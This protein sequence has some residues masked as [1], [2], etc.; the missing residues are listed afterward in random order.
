ME[1][2]EKLAKLGYSYHTD[3][4]N[5]RDLVSAL[6]SLNIRLPYKKFSVVAEEIIDTIPPCDGYSITNKIK[7]MLENRVLGTTKREAKKYLIRIL[8]QTKISYYHPEKGYETKLFK[9]GE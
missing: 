9:L 5:L 4:F 6:I 1:T 3:Y 8:E 2:R 7:M